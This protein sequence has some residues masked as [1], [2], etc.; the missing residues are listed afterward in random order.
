[1]PSG[2]EIGIGSQ[3]RTDARLKTWNYPLNAQE[4]RGAHQLTFLSAGLYQFSFD[5]WTKFKS[6][7][8]AT[9]MPFKF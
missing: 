2:I 4:V 5:D 3:L 8:Q 1:M 6:W 9:V 7:W